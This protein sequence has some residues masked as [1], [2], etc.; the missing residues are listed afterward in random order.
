MDPNTTTPAGF[1][2]TAMMPETSSPVGM[3]PTSAEN[4]IQNASNAPDTTLTTQPITDI[5][6]PESMGNTTMWIIIVIIGTF[7]LCL[8]ASFMAKFV[9][10]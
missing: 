8:L 1:T 4:I 7:L 9:R 6:A 5:N 2:D 3:T 10:K